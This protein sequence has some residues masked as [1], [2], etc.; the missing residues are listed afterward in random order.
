[1]TAK[2]LPSAA[3]LH[4]LLRYEPETGKLFWKARAESEFRLPRDARAWNNK[5]AG[6]EAGKQDVRGY[7]YICIWYRYDYAH[8][9]IWAMTRGEWPTLDIDHIDQDPTNNRAENLREVEHRVNMMNVLM[10]RDNTS[11]CTGVWQVP[12][13]NW[14]A[15][16]YTDGKRVYL[17]TF[18]SFETA[19]AVRKKAQ[20]DLGF[21]PNHGRA[22][23]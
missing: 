9:I 1:M 8:R 3:R 13:G 17:G 16:V 6:K 23:A 7:R 4:E 19:A 2:E 10:H 14:Q 18:S 11:G 20:A 15:S 22:T 12:S 5:N 21:S